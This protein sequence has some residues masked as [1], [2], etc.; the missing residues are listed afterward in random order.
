G[1][2]V[3]DAT[4]R[5]AEFGLVAAGLDLDFLDEVERRRVA[6]RAEDDRV[7]PQRAVAL[8]GDVHAV[9]HV[10]VVEA[11]PARNRGVRRARRPGAAD[12]GRHVERVTDPASDWHAL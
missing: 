5:L 9:N 4:G 6:E 7:G 2:D 12:A 11:A 1:D 10:L 8:I 3:D